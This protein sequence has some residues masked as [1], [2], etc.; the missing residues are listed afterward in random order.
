MKILH[1]AGDG[2]GSSTADSSGSGSFHAPLT[3]GGSMM[4]NQDINSVSLQSLPK[5]N[6][7]LLANQSNLHTIQQA[8]NVKA[9]IDQSEKMNFQSPHSLRENHVQSHLQQ[10]FEQQSHHFQPQL[11]QHQRLQKQQS[12]Q[13]QLSLKNDAFG[14]SLVQSESDLV[15]H[16]KLEPGMEHHDEALRPQVSEQFHSSEILALQ[17][18]PQDI[19]S[20]LAQTSQQMEQLLHHHQFVADSQNDF[21]H[22]I[23]VQSEAAHLGQWHPRSQDG[24][25]MPGV[26]SH[27]QDVQEE[28]RNRLTGQDEAQRNNFSSEGSIISQAVTTRIAASPKYTG[29]MC[30]SSTL[31]RE[32][33]FRNQQRWLLFLRH[34]RSCKYPEGKCPI[35][36]CIDAQKLWRHVERCNIAQCPHPRCD[37]TKALL[38][39]QRECRNPSCPVCIPV[40]NFIKMQ[41]KTI[42][43]PDTNS[44]LPCSVNRS[45][46]SHDSGDASGRLA[47]KMSP[48]VI[49]MSE[50]LHPSMKRMKIEQHSQSIPPKSESSAMPVPA[51]SEP[52]VLQDAQLEEHQHGGMC[53][54]MKSEV[55]GVKLEIPLSS[56]QASPMVIVTKKDTMDDTYIQRA[57]SDV[58]ISNAPAGFPKEERLKIEKEVDQ[59]KQE[60]VSLTSEN[61]S[62]TKSG[63]PKI[64]GVS[65]MELFTP[66]QVREHITGLRR[67]VGQVSPWICFSC[68]SFYCCFLLASV[69]HIIPGDF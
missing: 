38:K 63:K 40:R 47:S 69:A 61:T 59:G 29:T 36:C 8:G 14:Q 1:L 21:N 7:P 45:C 55:T 27:E 5:T 48:L 41:S 43:R 34:A 28:F 15:G 22:P 17:S 50:D 18:G 32:L 46:K 13:R 57:D 10:Q 31:N 68:A 12:Q 37:S 64:K 24:S 33:D 35:N 44:A 9:S 51:I 16:I 49:E 2:Y 52:H 3:S 53:V 39:H 54:P 19:C 20:S 23:G 30:T 25:H 65:L 62:G 26:M 60:N 66:E 6:F 58:I 4:N 56:A 11:V 67:W 42:T